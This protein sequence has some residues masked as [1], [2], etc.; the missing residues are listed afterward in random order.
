MNELGK[1]INL[2]LFAAAELMESYLPGHWMKYRFIGE[3]HDGSKMTIEAEFWQ[4]LLDIFPEKVKR[5]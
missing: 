5:K 3:L 2:E 4:Q 1:Y